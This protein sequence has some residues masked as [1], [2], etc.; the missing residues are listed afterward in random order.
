AS[1]VDRSLAVERPVVLAERDRKDHR[2]SRRSVVG[3]WWLEAPSRTSSSHE[4][5]ITNHSS[6][7]EQRANVL[8]QLVRADRA[9]ALLADQTIHDVV[10][11]AELLG[12]RRLGRGRDL[13]HVLQVGE[14]LLLDRLAQP[15]V[16]GVFEALAAPSQ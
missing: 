16:R 2:A 8:E 14:Q 6:P 10:D 7:I 9:V 12:V 4:P 11:A 5:P 13:D 3:G 1:L 15:L